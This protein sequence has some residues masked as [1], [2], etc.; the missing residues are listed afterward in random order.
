MPQAR[1]P[2]RRQL[3]Q[4]APF[5]AA[6]L[7][8]FMILRVT[9]KKPFGSG[10]SGETARH[11]RAD[12][13]DRWHGFE[14]PADGAMLL[15]AEACP[16]LTNQ[17]DML[18]QTKACAKPILPCAVRLQPARGR[19]TVARRAVARGICCGRSMSCGRQRQRGTS[20]YSAVGP[21]KGA[22][23]ILLSGGIFGGPNPRA[24]SR[25]RG[26]LV[27]FQ[28]LADGLREET[29]A[30]FTLGL[31][32][33]ILLGRQTTTRRPHGLAAPGSMAPDFTAGNMPPA[34]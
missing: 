30:P 20:C 13:A 21:I 7:Q 24:S 6:T 26:A 32:F 22:R 5:G 25:T 17:R 18:L 29:L 11:S 34:S 23:G 27:Y 9:Y 8:S 1:R 15:S 28:T 2:D 19:A 3:L 31:N 16:W 10:K 12:W 14:M 33:L 4:I